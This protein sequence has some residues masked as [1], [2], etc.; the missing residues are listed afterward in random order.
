MYIYV[1]Q[2]HADRSYFHKLI[3]DMTEKYEQNESFIDTIPAPCK[4]NVSDINLFSNFCISR[5]CLK[6]YYA[7]KAKNKKM[8]PFS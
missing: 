1:T 4:G 5:K 3:H 8:F 7:K 6:K 2:S